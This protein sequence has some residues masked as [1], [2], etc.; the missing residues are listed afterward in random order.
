MEHK[1]I[2]T[3]SDGYR[4]SYKID[5]SKE[6]PW[7]EENF[8][9]DLIYSKEIFK[10]PVR[11]LEYGRWIL[12]YFSIDLLEFISDEQYDKI[13]LDTIEYLDNNP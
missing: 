10:C 8:K 7:L 1:F 2:F 13:I 6:N 12:E 3:F 4:I 9:L 5:T 11:T